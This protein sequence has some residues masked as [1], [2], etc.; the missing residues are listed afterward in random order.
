MSQPDA[1]AAFHERPLVYVAAPYRSDPVQN[2]RQAILF[3]DRMQRVG[4]ITCIV[5]HLNLGWD[6]VQPHEAN[7][8]LEYDFAL[9]ARCDALFRLPG[10][11]PGADDEVRFAGERG[12]PVF[13]R[14]TT[15]LVWA[16]RQP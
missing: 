5:P 16:R 15:L 1:Y 10:E 4:G 6:L 12:I 14:E 8:W 13:Y 9:L 7:Y 11:S 3:A 2:T